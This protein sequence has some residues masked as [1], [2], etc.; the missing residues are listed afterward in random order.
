[1]NINPSLIGLGLFFAIAQAPVFAAVVPGHDGSATEGRAF[2]IQACGA[3]HAVIPGQRP[4]NPPVAAAPDFK[5]VANAKTTSAIG[6]HAFLVTP[7]QTMPNIILSDD[8]RE[9]VIAYILSLRSK[10]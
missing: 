3:C 10:K 4:R 2:A 5:A 8:A 7:H 9:D 1:M 6:L